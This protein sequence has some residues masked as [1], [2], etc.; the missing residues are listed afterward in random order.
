MF[1][2]MMI[3]I[4]LTRPFAIPS[5]RSSGSNQVLITFVTDS[6]IGTLIISSVHTIIDGRLRRIRFIDRYRIRNSDTAIGTT[7]GGHVLCCEK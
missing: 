3:L 4:R 5:W 7:N 2:F 1:I 6:I